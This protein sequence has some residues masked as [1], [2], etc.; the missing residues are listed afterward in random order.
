M[1][2]PDSELKDQPSTDGIELRSDGPLLPLSEN[3]EPKKASVHSAVYV[4]YV[5]RTSLNIRELIKLFSAWIAAS[6]GTI[7]YN[8]WLLDTL[9]FSEFNHVARL[10]HR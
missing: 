3:Q 4:S 10:K 5:Y 9:G 2:V 1:R 6:S 8:K 7:L